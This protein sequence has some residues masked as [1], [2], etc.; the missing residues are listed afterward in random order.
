MK[1]F[2]IELIVFFVACFAAY[3]ITRLALNK[4]IFNSSFLL[5]DL[6]VSCGATLGW[7]IV[8]YFRNKKK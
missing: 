8:A 1:K 4:F 5:D 7:G 3:L 6:F 2:I